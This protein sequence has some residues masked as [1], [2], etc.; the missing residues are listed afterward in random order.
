MKTTALLAAALIVCV[1]ACSKT[2]V[3]PS[4]ARPGVVRPALA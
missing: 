1:A 3:A 2:A 4:D